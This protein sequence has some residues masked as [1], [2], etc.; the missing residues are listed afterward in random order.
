[1]DELRKKY[2]VSEGSASDR[3][4]KGAGQLARS[5]K[6]IAGGVLTPLGS[7]WR[8]VRSVYPVLVVFD[9][10]LATP[11]HEQ[12]LANEFAQA[13]EPD[14]VT[15]G[16]YMRKGVFAVAPLAVITIAD[17]EGLE[18]SIENFRLSDLLRDYATTSRSVVRPSL[19]DFMASVQD[20]Y[21]FIHSRE[22]ASRAQKVL[23]DTWRM[24]FPNAP[25]P[26]TPSS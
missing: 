9:I 3:E 5:I 26:D 19:H 14:E 4:V 16:G 23:E 20:K 2:G 22:L 13:L 10:S 18:S 1:M 17:L 8:Q 12:F 7:D 25:F 21:R 15:P 6:E 24:T 11:G